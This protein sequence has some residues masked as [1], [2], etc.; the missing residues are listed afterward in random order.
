MSAH[1][2][3]NAKFLL[4]ISFFLS[5]LTL[6]TFNLQNISL[7]R[8]VLGAKTEIATETRKEKEFWLTFLEENP[9]YFEGWT[10]LAILE[11]GEGNLAKADEYYLKAK[12]IDPNSEKLPW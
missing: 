10:E 7:G 12:T 11:Y 1:F 3:E 9:S 2:R 8:Q 6:V 5:I 4:I